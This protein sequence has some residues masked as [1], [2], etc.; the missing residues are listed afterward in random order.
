MKRYYLAKYFSIL[1]GYT[2]VGLYPGEEAVEFFQKQL[3]EYDKSKGTVRL[4]IDKRMPYDLIS[5][6]ANWCYKQEIDSMIK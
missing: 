5:E 3:M 6:I 2:Y 4:P 1:D